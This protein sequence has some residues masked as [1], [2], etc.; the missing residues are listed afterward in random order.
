MSSNDVV[1]T[2]VQEYMDDGAIPGVFDPTLTEKREALMCLGLTDQVAVIQSAS[3]AEK[4]PGRYRA[5]AHATAGQRATHERWKTTWYS[6]LDERG[7]PR[8]EA[9]KALGIAA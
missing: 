3:A 5:Y 8:Q 6:L 1:R 7:I 9:L 4:R 2:L